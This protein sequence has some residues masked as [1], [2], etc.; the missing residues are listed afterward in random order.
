M[1]SLIYDEPERADDR[2][3]LC[4]CHILSSLVTGGR[5][6]V[7]TIP[8]VDYTPIMK[9]QTISEIT[10]NSKKLEGRSRDRKY[11]QIYTPAS[12]TL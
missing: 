4:I 10:K 2:A 11:V 6:G 8:V 9:P 7:K 3:S 5:M 12:D 1:T